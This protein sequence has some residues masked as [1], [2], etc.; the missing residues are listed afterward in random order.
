M[1]FLS[2]FTYRQPLTFA[3][4]TPL[5]GDVT[6]PVAVHVPAANTDFWANEDGAGGYVRF[7]AADGTTLLDFEVE[8]YDA[9]GDD[10]WFHVLVP[11]SGTADTTIY[12]YYA[13]D[14]PADGSDAAAV[15][16]D[17][18]HAFH[19]NA[20]LP[21]GSA[22]TNS[23][24]GGT[25]LSA[26][27]GTPADGAG[28]VDR[29]QDTSGGAYYSAAPHQLGNPGGLTV[30]GWF[31]RN[32]ANSEGVVTA[33]T[34]ASDSS[35]ILHT[36]S[37]GAMQFRCY[38][39]AG[40]NGISGNFTPTNGA[41]HHVVG[42]WDGA[43]VELYENGV[44]QGSGGGLTGS[45]RTYTH[46]LLVGSRDDLPTVDYF[47]GVLDEVT[48]SLAGKSAD[49]IKARH[50][51]GLGTW[52]SFGSQE[53]NGPTPFDLQLGATYRVR[54]VKGSASGTL[55]QTAVG[56]TATPATS[57]V[58]GSQV[59]ETANRT[60]NRLAVYLGSG[61]AGVNLAGGVYVNADTSQPHAGGFERAAYNAKAVRTAWN[62][63]A[64]TSP[65]TLAPGDKRW[66]R[67]ES[68]GTVVYQY[69]TPGG[70]VYGESLSNAGWYGT[71]LPVQYSWPTTEGDNA[72]NGRVY[73]M[74]LMEQGALD[75]EARYI[76]NLGQALPLGLQYALA[77]EP[78]ST[79]VPLAAA[80]AI[81]TTPAAVGLPS[82]YALTTEPTTVQ[83]SARY[84]V[85]TTLAPTLAAAYAVRA[86][87]GITVGLQ[88]ALPSAG[89]VG[90]TD[91]TERR[92]V[93]RQG[94]VAAVALAGTYTGSPTAIEARVVL[95]GTSTVA[96]DWATVDA[97]PAGGTWA[98]TITVPQGG[99]YNAQVRFA[100]STGITANGSHRWGVGVLV[101][102]IGQSNISH[103]WSGAYAG[104]TLTPS[105]RASRHTHLSG[106]QALSAG[107]ADGTTEF[108]NALIASL[109]VPVGLLLYAISGAALAQAAE[110]SAGYWLDLG[111]SAPYTLFLDGV[112]A[113][114]GNLE[115]VV[116]GQGER[117]AR[118]NRT[119]AQY[120]ADLGTFFTRMRSDIGADLSILFSM[121]G[122]GSDAGDT[123]A[124]FQGVRNAQ[125]TFCR[126]DPDSHVACTT[127]DLAMQDDIH[128]DD[129][130]LHA[131]RVAQ[132]FLTLAGERGY[133][134]G[135]E[136]VSYTI[137][138]NVVD[139]RLR[140]RGTAGVT[141]SL[142]SFTG[143][144]VLDGATPVT[145]SGA[146]AVDHRTIRLTLASTPGGAVTVRHLYGHLP[147]VTNVAVGAGSLALP[148]EGRAAIPAARTLSLT[149]VDR[150]D[151]PRV[152]LTGLRWA[153]FD[154][155][156]PDLIGAPVHQGI[157]ETTDGSGVLTLELP[158]VDLPVDG[159]AFLVVSDTD[160]TSGQSPASIAF[161]A[162]V[163]L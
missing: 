112:T 101:G 127:I 65:V 36:A 110:Q 9:S 16:A 19:L 115:A 17:F 31:K 20:D 143:W 82:R 32:S 163:N 139:V 145:V 131:D 23:V 39:T 75:L 4:N 62:V 21:G 141:P 59:V 85:R 128:Y 77:G 3:S 60:Y 102:L 8:S 106:W 70:S 5:T 49:W 11:L 53:D 88:Y 157:G 147:T 2:G 64:L 37:G 81:R 26:T 24:S 14:S 150:D 22:V 25:A 73:S 92:V 57:N 120:L 148:V 132:A 67:A 134:R 123:D 83:R 95:H 152:D 68:E 30:E 94:S 46:A 63:L 61:G 161:A 118:A 133:G 27:N 47:K 51:S 28:Q 34:T 96:V 137:N 99:W 124:K 122:S 125:E 135:P 107:T 100:N 1:G 108:A 44:K 98:G 162:P 90:L 74:Y 130:I 69:D 114:G 105:D 159:D 91:L 42:V 93:Q 7:T 121:L 78:T 160:G 15:W 29:G 158:D 140:N 142:S 151:N 33:Y 18:A 66:T 50:Q 97:A 89:T 58:A 116:W 119:E 146:V 154:L 126:A 40:S 109:N 71:G 43:T 12:L 80:Y 117:D 153:L 13:A 79:D 156:K 144:S 55:G 129:Y 52:L 103:W 6:V 41:W 10:G 155:S 48:V 56:G 35:F 72:P 104:S 38:N 138:A 87:V 136:T 111:G 84:T 86:P 45:L 76:V 54:T 149:L 113:A